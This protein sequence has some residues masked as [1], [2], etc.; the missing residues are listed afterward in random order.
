[1]R[2]LLA[3]ALLVLGITS[4]ANAVTCTQ[5]WSQCVEESSK[6]ASSPLCTSRKDVCLKTGKWP[7]D[8]DPTKKYERK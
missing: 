6:G 4:H 8:R 5:A 3:S 7:E 1:M 2:S